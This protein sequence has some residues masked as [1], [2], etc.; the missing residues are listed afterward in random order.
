MKSVLLFLSLYILIFVQDTITLKNVNYSIIISSNT[1]DILIKKIDTLLSKAIP[2]FGYRFTVVGDFNGDNIT[3]TLYERFTD[4][5]YQHEVPKYYERLD[6]NFDYSDI[7]F[8]NESLNYV[9]YIEWKN[10]DT[11]LFG[12]QLGF[13]YIENCG[14]INVD[15]KDEIL[16]VKQWS[17][18]SNI[19][20]AIIYTFDK[21]QWI[22]IY[23]IPVWEW[24]FPYSPSASMIPEMFGNYEIGFT[25]NDSIDKILEDSLKAFKFIT[26]FSDQSIEFSGMNPIPLDKKWSEEEYNKIGYDTYIKK[27]FKKVYINHALYLNDIKNNSLFYKAQEIKMKK[28]V[29]TLFDID[30]PSAMVTT[31]IYINHPQSPFKKIQSK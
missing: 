4:S 20:E 31:R 9:S 25:H 24:Q 23:T 21:N 18:Y 30:D 17:D 3:D 11:K 8:I 29:V 26:Y 22:Q 7:V 1:K 5:T 28:E 10:V 6:T 13:H 27:Y 16:V 19:N 15:G 12:G 2:V 14:D